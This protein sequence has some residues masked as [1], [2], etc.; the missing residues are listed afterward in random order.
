MEEIYKGKVIK[1][2]DGFFVSVG[3]V[4]DI[5]Y[6]LKV[7]ALSFSHSDYIYVLKYVIDYIIS[8]KVIVKPNEKIGF[9]SWMLKFVESNG[10]LEIYELDSKAED[11]QQGADFSLA[12]LRDQRFI[13]EKYDSRF[14]FPW[15]SQLVV[16]SDGVLEGEPVQGVRYESAYHMSGWWITTDLYNGDVNSLKRIH[17]PELIAR[18]PEL[19]KFLALDNGMRFYVEDDFEEAFPD[20]GPEED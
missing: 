15:S 8:E 20:E 14:L 13:C 10:F 18:R 9:N 5:R 4:N 12:L 3:L 17:L 16:I 19:G 6:E 11:Y 7:K 1:Y 2:I